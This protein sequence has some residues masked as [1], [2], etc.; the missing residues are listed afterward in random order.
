MQAPPQDDGIEQKVPFVVRSALTK[1]M[2]N[3]TNTYIYYSVLC[4]V[5][6]ILVSIIL[7][8]AAGVF[9]LEGWAG[10][11]FWCVGHVCI[12]GNVI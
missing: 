1:N 5:R 7:G 11:L 3:I 4:D 2:R 9:G 6:R 12:A 8:I 10:I